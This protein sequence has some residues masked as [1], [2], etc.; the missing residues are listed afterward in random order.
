[1]TMVVSREHC[2]DKIALPHLLYT[3]RMLFD[4]ACTALQPPYPQGAAWLPVCPMAGQP[5]RESSSLQNWTGAGHSR[6]PRALVKSHTHQ[7]SLALR[8]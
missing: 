2:G 5:H 3:S 8:P 7:R 1:M 6:I 4:S